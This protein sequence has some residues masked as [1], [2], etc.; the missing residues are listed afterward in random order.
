MEN[1]EVNQKEAKNMKEDHDDKDEHEDGKED[2][3]D[4]KDPPDLDFLLREAE[5]KNYPEHVMRNLR[6][7]FDLLLVLGLSQG[8]YVLV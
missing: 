3:E 2:D 7:K 6:K 4:D 5:E 1:K 8:V